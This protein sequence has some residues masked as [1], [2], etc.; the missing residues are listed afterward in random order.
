ML[1]VHNE[2]DTG[3]MTIWKPKYFLSNYG[4]CV[5]AYH[6]LIC[7]SRCLPVRC[8]PKMYQAL[9]CKGHIAACEGTEDGKERERELMDWVQVLV[10]ILGPPRRG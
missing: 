1:G 6:W 4:P 5:E 2:L 3:C 9:Q 10:D 8:H 7:S